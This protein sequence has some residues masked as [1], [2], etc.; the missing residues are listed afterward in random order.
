MTLVTGSKVIR[1]T[2]ANKPI[3]TLLTNE[4]FMS[5]PER[6]NEQVATAIARLDG[7][8]P[9]THDHWVIIQALRVHFKR[10]GPALPAFS[11]V[12]LANHMDKHCV[13]K[14]FHSQ[15]EAWRVAGLP[16]P[17]EEAR[18]YM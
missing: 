17:G 5:N 10:F 1:M 14:L 15:R 11:H 8:P 9:L 7:L 3:D 13:D 16:D 12:C 4:G 6:W 2:T 18:A